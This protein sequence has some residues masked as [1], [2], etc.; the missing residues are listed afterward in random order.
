MLVGLGMTFFKVFD[1]PVFWPILLMYWLL[2]FAVTM[3]R[4]IK[5]MIKYKYLPFTIGKKVRQRRRCCH[6]VSTPMEM[7]AVACP[8]PWMVPTEPACLI[9]APADVCWQRW[10]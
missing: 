10:S 6:C 8:C 7:V 5:H 3:K 2:L 9:R 4:Q 1:V